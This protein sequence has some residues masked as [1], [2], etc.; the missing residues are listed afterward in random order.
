MS[1]LFFIFIVLKFK[2]MNYKFI[3][4]LMLFFFQSCNTNEIYNSFATDFKDNR[5]AITDERVFDFTNTESEAVVSLKLHFGHIY[6]YQLDSIPLEVTITAP[7]GQTEV[8]PLDL[9]LKDSSGKDIGDC[10]GDICD[11]YF[12]IKPDFKLE[13][14]TYSFKIKNNFNG[15]YLPNV[16]GVGITIELPKQN[17]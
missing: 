14:G 1:G 7:N 16:L 13:I 3:F 17:E 11:V 12:Q 4:V 10:L 6:G 5:W 2:N 9:Q 15:P 8:I